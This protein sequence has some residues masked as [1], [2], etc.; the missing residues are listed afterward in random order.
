[1]TDDNQ[2]PMFGPSFV[3]DTASHEP[4]SGKCVLMHQ[5]MA[6]MI[7]GNCT[8]TIPLKFDFGG[9]HP[10][11]SVLIGPTGNAETH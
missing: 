2:P 7:I 10:R 6:A 9:T 11:H 4:H 1:M 3:I 8:A 5:M